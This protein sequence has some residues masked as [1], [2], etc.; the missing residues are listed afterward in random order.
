MTDFQ[1]G[2]VDLD[3]LTKPFPKHAIKQRQGGGNRMY[4]YVET[5]T[6]IRR[7]NRATGNRWSFRVTGSEWRNALL[8]VS[9][10]LTI[11]GLGTR[12]G[13]GVQLVSERGGE[14]LVK[15]GAS[16]CLKKC[17]TL[18]GVALELY[19]EDLEAPQQKQPQS[20]PPTP[21]EMQLHEDVQRLSAELD[22]CQSAG[23]RNIIKAEI[24]KLGL[25][26]NPEL[27]EHYQACTDR[28]TAAK[29]QQPV[30]A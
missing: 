22:D 19:G 4:D 9:G 24:V 3:E 18:F 23:A 11:P 25:T 29:A 20:R 5:D 12:S 10:E 8:I 30:L 26:S 16:D 15:G 13:T 1:D 14:D 2:S 17:A 27:A 28:L 21:L 7:L 6:V